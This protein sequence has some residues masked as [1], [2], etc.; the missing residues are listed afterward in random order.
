MADISGISQQAPVQRAPGAPTLPGELQA[1]L[2]NMSPA[3]RAQ[4]MQHYQTLVTQ[5]QIQPTSFNLID[6]LYKADKLNERLPGARVWRQAALEAAQ[7]LM[8]DKD[9]AWT[10]VGLGAQ[11]GASAA[12][13]M[14]EEMAIAR[15][16]RDRAE[17][18]AELSRQSWERD[19]NMLSQRRQAATD[20]LS[21][22]YRL[23]DL[24]ARAR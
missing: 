20:S 1:L 14:G 11:E 19:Q 16:A 6:F 17:A 12:K 18:A 8:S 21:L 9:L 15:A 24:E 7:G 2:A 5:R 22:S 4:T 23:Q 13:K 10:S 3:V